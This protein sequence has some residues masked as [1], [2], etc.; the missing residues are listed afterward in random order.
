PAHFGMVGIAQGQTARLNI[1]TALPVRQAVA[2]G[3]C[4][5]ALA[6]VDSTGQLLGEVVVRSLS[7]GQATFVDLS[8][9]GYQDP[10]PRHQFRPL[11]GVGAN[12]PGGGAGGGVVA[13]LEIFED[14]TGRPTVL[15]QD[16]N[17]FNFDG[18]SALTF[19]GPQ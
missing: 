15:Y 11:V 5:V 10:D 13:T 17:Q 1:V 6:F 18:A 4:R 2:P 12:Q 8:S 7:P 9:G 3:P 19:P 16:P 14:D